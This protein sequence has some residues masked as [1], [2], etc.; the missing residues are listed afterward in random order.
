MVGAGPAALPARG[1]AAV[2]AGL[3]A[4]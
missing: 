4:V 2:S 3:A 1:G